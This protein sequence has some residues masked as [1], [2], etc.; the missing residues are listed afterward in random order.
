MNAM[1]LLEKTDLPL[2]RKVADALARIA[3]VMRAESWEDF[4]AEGLNPTQGQILLLLKRRSQPLRLS[5]IAD[6][7]SVTAATVSDSVKALAEKS[8]VSKRRSAEDGR[9]LAL[10]L[11][12]RGEQLVGQHDEEATTLHQVLKTLPAEEQTMLYTTLLRVIRE[13]QREGKIPVAR[14]CVTCR[15]FRPSVHNNRSR[16]HHCALVDV[17]IGNRT[18]RNDCPD[19]ETAD[20]PLASKNW[21]RFVTSR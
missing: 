21:K 12:K 14:M 10:K 18:L 20:E 9:A 1:N 16:P 7:L 6:E 17:A 15:Y 5:E 19:H 13:L 2:D 4:G 3:V 8:L 11:T